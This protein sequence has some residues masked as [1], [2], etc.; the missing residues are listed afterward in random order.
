MQNE[1]IFEQVPITYYNGFQIHMTPS[2]AQISIFLNGKMQAVIVTTHMTA[3]NLREKLDISV[4]DFE[5]KFAPIA[6]FDE[7][8]AK[9]K[10]NVP[11][12]E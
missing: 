10:E 6:N 9:F 5:K 4:T 11:P 3:K 1:E 12:T 7:I 2:D 8:A